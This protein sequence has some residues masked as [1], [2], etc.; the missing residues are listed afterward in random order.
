VLTSS[1]QAFTQSVI[2]IALLKGYDYNEYPYV[3]MAGRVS[4][5][6]IFDVKNM[7]VIQSLRVLISSWQSFVGVV[8]LPDDR[9]A[10]GCLDG[11]IQVYKSSYE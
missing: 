3:A 10:V 8:G 1:Q 6:I 4:K 5:I 9:L 7:T 11:N 2:Y